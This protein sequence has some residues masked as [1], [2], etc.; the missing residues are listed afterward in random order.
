MTVTEILNL[1]EQG[2]YT[3]HE[4][5]WKIFKDYDITFLEKEISK[6]EFEEFIKWAKN[7][8]EKG[9]I[10]EFTSINNKLEVRNLFAEKVKSFRKW[11][12]NKNA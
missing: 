5:Y 4:I 8:F 10:E 2:I 12:E 3:K 11:L 6:T 7:S 1:Y 9:S